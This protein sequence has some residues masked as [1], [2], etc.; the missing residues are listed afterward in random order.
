MEGMNFM[1]TLIQ[2]M[3]LRLPINLRR[4]SLSAER[5]DVYLN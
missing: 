2:H 1:S 5:N 3:Y 4:G